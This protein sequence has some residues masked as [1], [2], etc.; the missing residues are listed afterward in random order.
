[1]LG[2]LGALRDVRLVRDR[3]TGAPRGFCFAEYASVADAARALG[4][5]QGARV[6]GQAS[7][8]RAVYAK[9]RAP[10]G[11]AAEALQVTEPCSRRCAH[12]Q[13]A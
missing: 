3:F 10:T 7:L 4:G 9:E 6:A 12:P 11:A 13:S 8:L 1:M 5:L 2:A